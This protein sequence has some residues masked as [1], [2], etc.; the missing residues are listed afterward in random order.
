MEQPDFVLVKLS[1]QIFQ[2]LILQKI[3]AEEEI[4]LASDD[5]QFIK[6]IKR[7]LQ[8]T[9]G[10]SDLGWISATEAY[11]NTMFELRSKTAPQVA[12]GFIQSL[13]D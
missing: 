9:Y 1:L 10:T 11:L 7:L 5:Q 3:Q 13:S 12:V 8:Q 2:K 4:K 6:S